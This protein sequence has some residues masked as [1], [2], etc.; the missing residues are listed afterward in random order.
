[1]E[2]VLMESVLGYGQEGVERNAE[3]WSESAGKRG[4]LLTELRTVPVL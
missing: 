2:V 4:R 3:P 1:M